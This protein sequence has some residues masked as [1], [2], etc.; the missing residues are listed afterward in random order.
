MEKSPSRWV[1][2]VACIQ[3]R[4][5]YQILI[6]YG[7]CYDIKMKEWFVK[8]SLNLSIMLNVIW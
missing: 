7:L 4:K 3:A 1:V 5:A 8:F 2:V 6:C